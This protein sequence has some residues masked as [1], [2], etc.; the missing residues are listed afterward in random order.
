MTH[1]VAARGTGAAAAGGGRAPGVPD[2]RSGSC[3]RHVGLRGDDRRWLRRLA[4]RS[5]GETKLWEEAVPDR[6]EGGPA[7]SGDRLES[8]SRDLARPGRGGEAG[9]ESGAA[10]TMRPESRCGPEAPAA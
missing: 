8:V 1:S 2:S 6:G 10:K 5:G 3:S 4:L 7:S 9:E